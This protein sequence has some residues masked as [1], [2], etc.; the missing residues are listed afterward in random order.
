MVGLAATAALGLAMVGS[1]NLI[2]IAFFVL[3]VGLGRRLRHSVQRALP[4]RTARTRRSAKGV[5]KRRREGRQ[6]ARAGCR[7][8]RCRIFCLSADQ[9]S[10][11]FRI[12]ADCRLR[13]ADRL[14]LQHHAGAGDADR[15]QSAGRSRRRRAS[16]RLAPLDDFLQRHRIRCD[17]R[18]DP[19]GA[20]RLAAAVASAVRLQSGRSCKT[21]TRRRS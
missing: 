11:S 7:G 6:A 12:G 14:R 17:R 10:R 4:H 15:A 19:R 5:A 13:H 20:G 8:N 18:H 16:R 9:L 2:S 1:F 3:F 21:R